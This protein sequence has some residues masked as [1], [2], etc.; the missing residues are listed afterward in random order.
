VLSEM[1]QHWREAINRWTRLNRRHKRRLEGR[2]APDRNDEYLLYQTL[3]G[4]WPDPGSATPDAEFVAR[5]V[6]YMEK[7][8][9]EAQTHTS[10]LT[11]NEEYESATT[12]FVEALLDPT[13]SESFLQDLAALAGTVAYFGALNGLGQQTLK[14]TAPGVPDIYQGTE[15]WNF[16][17]VDP[18][19]RRPVDFPRRSRLLTEL[20][21]LPSGA[22]LAANVQDGRI[23][24]FVTKTLLHLRRDRPDLF[25]HGDY[26]PLEVLGERAAH[27]LAFRRRLTSDDS[28]SVQELIVAVPR[29]NYR[30]LNG[31]ET[32]PTGHEIWGSTRLAL[33]ANETGN[34]YRNV[35]TGATLRAGEESDRA[36]LDLSEVLADFPVAVLVRN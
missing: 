9:R 19:N 35:F 15:L 30:L 36:T 4:T 5:I 24:L 28:E 18:D 23:K 29:L 16:S 14:L 6:A 27:V 22:S 8:T 26:S 31:Q 12:A 1:P 32:L 34:E 13:V 10:W 21:S 20:A 25:A 33:A 3:L 17:L 11:P 2:A 7:A